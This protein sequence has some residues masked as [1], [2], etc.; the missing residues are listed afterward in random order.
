MSSQAKCALVLL[1]VG[2]SLTGAHSP[3]DDP[4]NAQ[5]TLGRGY[6]VDPST[7]LMWTAKDNGKDITWNG[8]IKYCR[9]LRL[10]GYSDWRLPDMAAL[11]PIYDSRV[12][13]PG[14]AGPRKKQRDFTWHV[15]G[16]LFLTGIQWSSNLV[17]GDRGRPSGYAY[18]FDFN[19][20]KPDE[21]QKGYADG[22]RALCVRHPIEK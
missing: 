10:A 11:Q 19:S 7:G 3:A 18:Y 5:Q 22:K 15:K 1:F 6:W 13:A 8:A 9:E 14:L 4:G 12:E 16:N 17:F 21:D 20:G 2:A